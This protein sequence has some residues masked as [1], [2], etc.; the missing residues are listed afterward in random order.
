MSASAVIV[1]ATGVVSS[2]WLGAFVILASITLAVRAY[3]KDLDTILRT[4]DT[5]F[6]IAFIEVLLAVTIQLSQ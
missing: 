2:V 5:L 6:V 4:A 1:T 3:K